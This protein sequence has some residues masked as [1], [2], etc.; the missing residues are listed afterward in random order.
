[1]QKIKAQL[2]NWHA[3]VKYLDFIKN[4]VCFLENIGF[5]FLFKMRRS[6]YKEKV[7]GIQTRHWPIISIVR[8]MGNLTMQQTHIKHWFPK[9][10]YKVKDVCNFQ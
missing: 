2:W 6:Q 9:N 4:L 10:L 7:R 1:M 8:L 5:F 3:D